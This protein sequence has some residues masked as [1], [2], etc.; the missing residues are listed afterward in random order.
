MRAWGE[1][2]GTAGYGPLG[3]TERPLSSGLG[4][5]LALVPRGPIGFQGDFLESLASFI[6]RCS[7]ELN[8]GG[9]SGE[10]A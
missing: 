4:S 5:M 2:G 6:F 3:C 1:E 8:R 7:R 10:G 9:D